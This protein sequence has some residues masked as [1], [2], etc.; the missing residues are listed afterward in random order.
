[1]RTITSIPEISLSSYNFDTNTFTT[2]YLSYMLQE[3]VLIQKIVLRVE[4]RF[5]WWREK[6]N[7]IWASFISLAV[8]A[9]CMVGTMEFLNHHFPEGEASELAAQKF[10]FGL[11]L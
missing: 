6:L 2:F 8:V 3:V 9:V 5:K 4:T 10:Q 11:H 7:L 1:M